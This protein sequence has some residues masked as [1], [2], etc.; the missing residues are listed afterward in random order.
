MVPK[1][2][3]KSKATSFYATLKF[4]VSEKKLNILRFLKKIL[5]KDKD[6]IDGGASCLAVINLLLKTRG[7]LEQEKG[8]SLSQLNNY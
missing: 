2:L 4:L 3:S 8:L 6:K 7:Y 1:P 5:R